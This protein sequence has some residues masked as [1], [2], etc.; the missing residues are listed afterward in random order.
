MLFSSFPSP[1]F[2]SSAWLARAASSAGAALLLWGLSG[3]ALAQEPA[4]AAPLTAKPKTTEAKVEKP[5]AVVQKNYRC[6]G[7]KSLSV[8][9]Q[10]GTRSVHAFVRLQGKTRELPW[11]GDYKLESETEDERFSDGRYEL[12]V[13]G[14]FSRVTSVRRLPSQA[15]AQAGSKGRELLRACALP[16]AQQQAQAQAAARLEKKL[17]KAAEKSA[18]KSNDRS[19]AEALPTLHPGAVQDAHSAEHPSQDAQKEA[20]EKAPISTPNTL[21]TP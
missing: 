11:D 21:P 4:S 13:Q 14:N 8:R 19:K 10:L 17:G 2:C 20:H 16:K 1:L 7:G 5:S 6:H 18:E 12:L 15:A 9:Y 3:A